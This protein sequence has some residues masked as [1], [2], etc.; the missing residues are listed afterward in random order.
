[1]HESMF[2]ALSLVKI[3]IRESIH[4]RPLA[5]IHAQ[6]RCTILLKFNRNCSQISIR[7]EVVTKQISRTLDGVC[8]AWMICTRT[9]QGMGGVA[10]FEP[11]CWPQF[12]LAIFCSIPAAAAA[13]P[14][15]SRHGSSLGDGASEEISRSSEKCLMWQTQKFPPSVVDTV[16]VWSTDVAAS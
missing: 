11:G 10:W 5:G 13:A 3:K 9:A 1:M 12:E 16:A 6:E 7:N 2:S 14:A 4:H 15:S 8:S